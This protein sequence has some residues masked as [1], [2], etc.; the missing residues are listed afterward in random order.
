MDLLIAWA[1]IDFYLDYYYYCIIKFIREDTSL[2]MCNI[3]TMCT[4]FCNDEIE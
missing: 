4:A 1:G 3:Q 2:W